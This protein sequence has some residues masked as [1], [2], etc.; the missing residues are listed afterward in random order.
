M[1]I[2]PKLGHGRPESDRNKSNAHGT[3]LHTVPVGQV[4]A[5]IA[6]VSLQEKEYLSLH[7]DNYNPLGVGKN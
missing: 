7:S 6:D 5:L 3:S 1:K 2:S 4:N